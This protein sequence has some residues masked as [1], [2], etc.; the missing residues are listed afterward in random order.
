MCSRTID[1][2]AELEKRQKLIDAFPT[3]DEE[4]DCFFKDSEEI[5]GEPELG[6]LGPGLTGEYTLYHY[7]VCRNGKRSVAL[8]VVAVLLASPGTGRGSRCRLWGIRSS[9]GW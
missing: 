5:R 9:A 1:P 3:D 7:V 6:G 2:D 8:P 4:C